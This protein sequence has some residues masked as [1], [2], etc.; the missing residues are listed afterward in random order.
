MSNIPPNRFNDSPNALYTFARYVWG[1]DIRSYAIPE[2][3]QARLLRVTLDLQNSLREERD[4]LVANFAATERTMVEATRLRRVMLQRQPPPAPAARPSY[5]GRDRGPEYDER[6]N[7]RSS[8]RNRARFV[9][10]PGYHADGV[11]GQYPQ[12]IEYPQAQYPQGSVQ[13]MQPPTQQMQ[14]AQ[15][16]AQQV[17]YA[18]PPTQ[19]VQYAQPPTQQVQYAQPPA[20]QAQY[21]QAPAQH[22]QAPAAHAQPMM[23]P[24][25]QYP[26]VAGPTRGD[27]S[28]AIA[29]Q[30]YPRAQTRQA[31]T[32]DA[33]PTPRRRQPARRKPRQQPSSTRVDPPEMRLPASMELRTLLEEVHSQLAP[34]QIDAPPQA[35]A[36]PPMPAPQ[37]TETETQAASQMETQAATETQAQDQTGTQAQDQT[38]TQAQD[39]AATTT[40]IDSIMNSFVDF[41]AGSPPSDDLWDIQTQND[42]WDI[43]TQSFGRWVDHVGRAV[44]DILVHSSPDHFPLDPFNNFDLQSAGAGPSNGYLTHP[45]PDDQEAEDPEAGPS[46]GAGVPD[47]G[48]ER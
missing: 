6:N 48:E 35:Q 11:S 1:E 2:D 41:P 31:P 42:L 38:E 47:D 45:P 43:Q 34:L 12:Q 24:P 39:Q 8:M 5:A 16:P 19:Q 33:T 14:Y 10:P 21:M 37:Q 22:M 4:R 20:Q 36:P 9:A 30:P 29:H 44:S 26:Q 25:A 13:Y 23:Q 27:Q 28:H 40:D 17:Q 15:P 18:Q 32:S 7:W 3:E 46:N